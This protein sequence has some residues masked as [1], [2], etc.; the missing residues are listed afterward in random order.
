MTCTCEP[1]DLMPFGEC[2]CNPE[3]NEVINFLN[4]LFALG[5][6]VV[7]PLPD[8][9]SNTETAIFYILSATGK[10][11]GDKSRARDLCKAIHYLSKEVEGK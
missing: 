7:L 9:N 4:K 10:E 6:T 8:P 1:S 11:P 5:N 2:Q 3:S